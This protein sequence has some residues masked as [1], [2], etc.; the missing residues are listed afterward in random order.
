LEPH[1]PPAQRDPEFVSGTG[2][3]TTPG[4]LIAPEDYLRILANPFLGLAGFVLWVLGLRWVLL[5]FRRNPDLIGPLAPILVVLFVFALF[6]LVPA[7]LQY[8]CLDCGQTG[9][10][11]RWRSHQCLPSQLRRAA[12]R[13]RWVRGP[14]P[15]VQNI[16]WLWGLLMLALIARF[17]GFR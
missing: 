8:H 11:G 9:R 12:G 13:P 6:G 7:L 2:L 16:L 1:G 4:P 14:S 10:L 15:F 3:A 17:G 5:L